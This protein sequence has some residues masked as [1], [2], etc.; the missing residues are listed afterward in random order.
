[1]QGKKN[2]QNKP[3]IALMPPEAIVEIAKVFDFGVQK[4]DA[5]NW[6]AGFKWRRLVSAVLRHTFAWLG[7]EDKDPESGLSHLA[8][9]AC[10]IMMLIA[11]EV[12]KSGEDDR[13]KND[14]R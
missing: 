2:D 13:W 9:A 10:G 7:G 11:F 12:T 1:M 6:R 14:N 3:P 8:H 4:Y 5:D